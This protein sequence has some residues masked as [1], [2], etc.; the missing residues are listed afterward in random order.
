VKVIKHPAFGSGKIK[1]RVVTLSETKKRKYIPNVFL[2]EKKSKSTT[3]EKKAAFQ[4]H[5][6]SVKILFN[7]WRG[8]GKPFTRHGLSG[9]Q[10]NKC[11][12]QLRLILKLNSQKEISEAFDLAKEF[13]SDLGFKYHHQIKKISLTSFINYGDLWEHYYKKKGFPKSWLSE[14]LKGREYIL[15]KYSFVKKEHAPWMTQK[16]V[17]IWSKYKGENVDTNRTDFKSK[18]VQFSNLLFRFCEINQIDHAYLLDILDKSLNQWRT[19][20][21]RNISFALGPSFYRDTIPEELRRYNKSL[22][23][24]QTFNVDWKEMT[25]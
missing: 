21:L 24:K 20:Y 12:Y 22:H 11:I 25:K 23:G 13:F 14:F 1:R 9:K 4:S 18:I 17:D 5:D 7:H 8:L 15:G 10:F 6:S 19:I 16:L 3:A 2:P